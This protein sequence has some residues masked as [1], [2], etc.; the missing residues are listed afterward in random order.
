MAVAVLVTT[1][2]QDQQELAVKA[3][4]E[5]FGPAQLAHSQIWQESKEKYVCKN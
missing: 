4:S 2:Q 1:T 5:S 3:Q